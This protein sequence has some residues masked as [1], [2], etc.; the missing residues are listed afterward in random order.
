MRD[1]TK[2]TPL[3]YI[4]HESSA[5]KASK[6]TRSEQNRTLNWTKCGAEKNLY[7]TGHIRLCM[8]LLYSISICL[9][10]AFN[11]VEVVNVPPPR[12]LLLPCSRMAFCWHA[13]HN[14]KFRYCCWLSCA[15]SNNTPTTNWI[16]STL[17]HIKCLPLNAK[18]VTKAVTQQ[19]QRTQSDERESKKKLHINTTINSSGQRTAKYDI[20]FQNGRRIC[21]LSVQMH[22]SFS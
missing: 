6:K 21:L 9:N 7:M 13:V 8:R 22:I 12:S 14:T 20:R 10:S 18:Q 4:I 11:V 2:K 5:A 3:T 19:S 1:N 16:S 15:G 17:K